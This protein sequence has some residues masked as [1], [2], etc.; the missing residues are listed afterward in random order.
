MNVSQTTGLPTKLSKR[1]SSSSDSSSLVGIKWQEHTRS[2]RLVPAPRHHES[3]TLDVEV[4]VLRILLQ[5]RGRRIN[6]PYS[7]QEYQIIEAILALLVQA[8]LRTKRAAIGV[9]A[10][11][12]ELDAVLVVSVVV[13]VVRT[14]HGVPLHLARLRATTG[15]W[16]YLN[17]AIVHAC[18]AL[19]GAVL[20]TCVLRDQKRTHP[21][22]G[23]SIQ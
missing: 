15:A 12:S 5:E 4:E 8:R 17:R 9:S 3:L 13:V 20:C 7:R 21:K 19:L 1:G 18:P 2:I 6:V 14:V 16:V 10:T 22:G 23:K 11:M